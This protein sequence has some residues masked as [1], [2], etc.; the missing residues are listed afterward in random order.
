MDR[1]FRA[2]GRVLID[3]D[4]TK[5]EFEF[6]IKN[7]RCFSDEN[8][9]R[10]TIRPGF[11]AFV[12]VNN[13]GKSSLLRLF[14]ELRSVFSIAYNVLSS[15]L[16]M[17]QPAA[18]LTKE[19]RV[20]FLSPVQDPDQIF[21]DTNNRDLTVV[22]KSWQSGSKGN[23][24]LHPFELAITIRRADKHCTFQIITPEGPLLKGSETLSTSNG[25]LDVSEHLVGGQVT[26]TVFLKPIID[27]LFD[28][29]GSLY[30][31]PFRNAVNIPSSTVHR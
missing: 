6:T 8:P 10:F 15:L 19:H 11:T 29:I 2:S 28:L 26:D 14:Y 25:V 12:G 17:S 16:S 7:Y 5:M 3:E 21:T 30:V 27:L 13:S 1:D 22:I 9:A 23:P 4:G 24:R 20:S 18:L 31:G